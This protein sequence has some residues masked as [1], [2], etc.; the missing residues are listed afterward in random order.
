MLVFTKEVIFALLCSVFF[1]TSGQLLQKKAS[2]K[3]S[4]IKGDSIYQHLLSVE[5]ITST[6]FLGAGLIFWMLVLRS[7][8]LSLAYPLL[9]INYV[10]ILLGARYWFGEIIPLRRWVGV[11]FILTGIGVLMQGGL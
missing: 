7:V 11:I 9:S 6:L 1:T 3:Y 10:V 5:I 8:E 4:Q 2:L